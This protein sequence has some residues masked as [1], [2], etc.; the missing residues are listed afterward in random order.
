MGSYK[1]ARLSEDIKRELS[2]LLREL[3]DPR[4]K[5]R[6]ISFVRV[7]VSGDGSFAKVYVSAMEGMDAAK[8][9]VKG[10]ESASGHL[11]RE[12]SNKLHMRKCPEFKFIPDDSIA[13]GAHLNKMFSDIKGE[14]DED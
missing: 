11:K 13:Y 10:L 2:V 5:D 1:K 9:A 3:K 6:F 14:S 8:E 7:E 4:I 12:I